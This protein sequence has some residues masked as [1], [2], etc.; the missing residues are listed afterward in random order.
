MFSNI[1]QGLYPVSQLPSNEKSPPLTS[2]AW[3]RKC[4]LKHA[5]VETIP[6]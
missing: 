5:A 6:L 4:V 1:N 2:F 3:P